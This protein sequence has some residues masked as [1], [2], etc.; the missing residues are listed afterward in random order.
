MRIQKYCAFR[1]LCM[2][3]NILNI[4]FT[5]QCVFKY[6]ERKR[7]DF[8]INL[9]TRKYEKKI[10]VTYLLIG[11]DEVGE[12]HKQPSE[13]FHTCIVVVNVDRIIPT[14]LLATVTSLF[15]RTCAS[16]MKAETRA[17]TIRTLA[18]FVSRLCKRIVYTK[19]GMRYSFPLL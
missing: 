17:Y 6:R 11:F 7:R 12:K 8:I 4:K 9:I 5:I 3:K 16:K 14:I 19:R 18:A 10:S 13:Y 2:H 15:M 1:E